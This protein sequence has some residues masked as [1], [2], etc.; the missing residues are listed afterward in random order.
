MTGSRVAASVRARRRKVA[1]FMVES[2]L[3]SLASASR[4]RHLRCALVT[5]DLALLDATAQADL[6]ARGDCHRARARRCRDR[7]HRA[8][9]RPAQRGHPSALRAR[10][11]RGARRRRSVRGRAVPRQGRGVPH[12]RRPVSRR[13]AGAEGRGL[14][15]ARR[16]LARGALSRRGLRVRRQDQ[17]ARARDEHHDRTARVRRRRTTR[18]T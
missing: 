7:T 3:R 14:D 8:H 11:R 12:R 16:H 4:Q 9:R 15:R 5:D 17:H 1:S 13:H 6:V 18:G 10:P 2:H